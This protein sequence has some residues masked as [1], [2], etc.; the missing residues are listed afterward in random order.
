[1]FLKTGI[2]HLQLKNHNK[3]EKVMEKENQKNY[4]GKNKKKS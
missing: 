3:N 2:F 1:M 4:G